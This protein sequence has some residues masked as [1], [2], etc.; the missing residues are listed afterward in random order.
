MLRVSN[1]TWNWASCWCFP[2]FPTHAKDW[3]FAEGMPNSFKH[4]LCLAW[5]DTAPRFARGS[6]RLA[7]PT[8]WFTPPRSGEGWGSECPEVR[9]SGWETVLEG[10]LESARVNQK[11]MSC[12]AGCWWVELVAADLHV[13]SQHLNKLKPKTTQR[14]KVF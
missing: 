4:T 10:A 5:T 9:R 11:R 2:F 1:S 12:Q 6:S 7:R 8:L 14:Q 13:G 3:D